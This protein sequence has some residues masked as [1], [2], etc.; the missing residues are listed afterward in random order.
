MSKK[1]NKKS[2]EG[3]VYS[4][5]PDFDYSLEKN[6]TRETLPPAEQ[7]I[8]VWLDKKQR[9]GKRV[10]LVKGFI[11]SDD[12]LKE[13]G[14]EVK[15]KCGTGG[16]VKDGEIIIQGDFRDKVIDFLNKEGYTNI[17]KAGS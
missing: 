17:K 4:T 8:R 11:G 2:N 9:A 7:E 12:D 5:D 16:S 15:T 10:T 1:K 14:K 13:L 3:I 6:E